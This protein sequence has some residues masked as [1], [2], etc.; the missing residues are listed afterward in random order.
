MINNF[1]TYL[2]N[3]NIYLIAN[4]G[5]IPF[6]LMIL[7][8]PNHA[9]TKF[10]VHSIILPLILS[11]AYIFVAYKIYLN[12]NIFEGFQLY[13]G[14]ESLYTV[15]SNESFL[16]VFWLHFLSISLFLGSWM[17]RDG[18]K[19]F[20]PRT[21]MIIPLLL[22]YFTGPIGLFIYWIIRLFFAKKISYN[23]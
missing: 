21:L 12:E 6:W 20:I 5:V 15:F 14:L 2:T 16:L 7:A 10:F 9:L 1:E 13:L 23:D 8:I 19:Y 18:H 11:T 17:A 22:T 4:W 3:E